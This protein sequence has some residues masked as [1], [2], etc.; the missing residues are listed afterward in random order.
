MDSVRSRSETQ[1]P[2]WRKWILAGGLVFASGAL[3]IGFHIYRASNNARNQIGV[4]PMKTASA[5]AVRSAAV[6][7][8]TEPAEVYRSIKP[9]DG[10]HFQYLVTEHFPFT[11]LPYSTLDKFGLVSSGGNFIEIELRNTNLSEGNNRNKIIWRHSCHQIRAGFDEFRR[12]RV[13]DQPNEGTSD[14]RR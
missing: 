3:E 12:D 9:D 13:T 11:G 6:P 4:N 2:R 10:I 7:S 1:R 14:S 5:N 8:A